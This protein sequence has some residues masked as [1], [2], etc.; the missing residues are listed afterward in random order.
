MLS[1]NLSLEREY[2]C[3]ASCISGPDLNEKVLNPK[4]EV[5]DTVG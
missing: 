3:G 4:L 1:N 5:E 2:T